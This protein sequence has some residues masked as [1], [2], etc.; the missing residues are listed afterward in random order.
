MNLNRTTIAD[1]PRAESAELHRKVRRPG[2]ALPQR[3]QLSFEEIAELAGD[4]FMN[5]GVVYETMRRLARRLEEEQIDYAVLGA[6]ALAAHGY[7]R[8]TLDVDILLTAEG[9]QRFHERL[10]DRGY[11][12]A[13]PGAQ[14]TFCDVESKIKIEVITSGEYP[15]DG[16]PKPVAFPS[17]AQ[18]EFRSGDVAYVTL[19]KLVELK[20]ASGMTAPHRMRDLADVQDLIIAL[21]LPFDFT[22]QLDHSV[23]AEY[24]R[25]WLAAQ[26]GIGT[27]EGEL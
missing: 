10:V 3:T 25:I 26:S 27:S 24:E 21:N 8:F 11:V 15:G 1:E 18:H 6:M 4:F 7:P 16:L 17:P 2:F 23:Y 22:Q 12:P 20:L 19:E 9:L 14:K 13:F 5:K